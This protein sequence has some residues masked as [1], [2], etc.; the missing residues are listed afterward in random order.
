M[1]P[2]KLRHTYAMNLME[3][4]KDLS[5]VMEQLG[6]S[7]EITALLYVHNSQE[8]AKKSAEALGKRRSK[9]KIKLGDSNF[10]H[11]NYLEV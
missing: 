2:H 10:T 4:T 9:L 8:K 7:S 3:E 1:S 5:F 11:F 6:H